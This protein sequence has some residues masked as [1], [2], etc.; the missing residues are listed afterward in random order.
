M[1]GCCSACFLCACVCVR[2]AQLAAELGHASAVCHLTSQQHFFGEAKS[3]DWQRGRNGGSDPEVLTGTS[4][5]IFRR[6]DEEELRGQKK[7]K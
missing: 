6:Q 3:C 1:T 4:T 2:A 5:P 7:K